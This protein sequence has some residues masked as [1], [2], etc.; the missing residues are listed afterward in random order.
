LKRQDLKN[1][2]NPMK[3]FCFSFFCLCL[4]CLCTG[5]AMFGGGS[6]HEWYRGPE[7]YRYVSQAALA[8]AHSD[9]SAMYPGRPF[10]EFDRGRHVWEV[11]PGN[12]PGTAW[13][14]TTVIDLARG[15]FRTVVEPGYNDHRAT[16]EGGHVIGWLSGAPNADRDQ[17]HREFSR[18]FGRYR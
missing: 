3:S 14:E 11:V 13:A 1:Q 4:V 7:E 17:H 10:R 6:D 12:V 9:L 5:C 18:F 8:R 2:G 15:H 16:H